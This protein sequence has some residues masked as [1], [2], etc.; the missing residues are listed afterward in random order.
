MRALALVLAPLAACSAPFAGGADG[1]PSP[2]GGPIPVVEM[3]DPSAPPAQADGAEAASDEAPAAPGVIE[4]VLSGAPAEADRFPV[5][6]TQVRG[7]QATP[8]DPELDRSTILRLEEIA[9]DLADPDFDQ[10]AVVAAGE[11]PA[12]AY[13]GVWISMDASVI[14]EEGRMGVIAGPLQLEL[15]GRFHVGP[16]TLTRVEIV[17]D[18]EAS[19]VDTG[20]GLT[21]EP[22]YTFRAGPAP[23]QQGL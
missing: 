21:L 1:A 4:L 20:D 22:S 14:E 5:T 17:L 15:P 23:G 6:V 9:F 3:D 16:D 13:E 19:L 12:G 8:V 2:V 7:L 10:P 11:V 18:V